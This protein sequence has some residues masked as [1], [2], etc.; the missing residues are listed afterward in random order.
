MTRRLLVL[1][2]LAAVVLA[3]CTGGPGADATPEPTVTG[4]PTADDGGANAVSA[5]E[6]PGVSDGTLTNATALAR[7][8]QGLL[9]ETG[10]KIHMRQSG[11]WE[12]EST[13]TVGTDA[14]TL[15]LAGTRSTDDGRSVTTEYWSNGTMTYLRTETGGETRYRTADR[16]PGTFERLDTILGDYLAAG[17]FTVA[18]GSAADGT[19]VLTADGFAPPED[20][21]LLEDATSLDGRVVVGQAG[22]IHNLTITAAEDGAT[23][24]YRYELLRSG[25]ERA[26]RPGWLDDVPA[27]AMLRPE[28]SVGIGD[29]S[30]LIVENEG[31]DRVPR[32]ATLAVTT[33]GTTHTATFESA[34]EPGDTRYAYLASADGTLRLVADRP[35]GDVVSP[36]TSPV[37]VSIATAD[38]VD[39]HSGGIAWSSATATAGEGGDASADASGTAT[40]S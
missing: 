15:A 3:G 2:A 26:D 23:V 16:S 6:I 22:R 7:A 24:A 14:G 19:V 38:G 9:S 5:E 37:S 36:V 13:L 1:V 4:T 12:A 35:S 25:V 31:G 18:D 8:N 33:G 28:L 10:A 20:A 30:Y 34:L 11:E 27:S 39:L 17:A 29:E 40:A 32:N 21:R